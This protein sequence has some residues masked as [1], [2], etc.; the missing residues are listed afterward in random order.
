MPQ[1]P[2]HRTLVVYILT[3]LHIV[4]NKRI[5]KSLCPTQAFKYLDNYQLLA[6]VNN[7]CHEIIFHLAIAKA[8]YTKD[9]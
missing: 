8:N 4:Y 2:I 1:V 5:A 3:V 7:V 9:I 6:P